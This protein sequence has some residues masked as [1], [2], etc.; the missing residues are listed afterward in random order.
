MNYYNS[1]TLLEQQAEI[2]KLKAERDALAAQVEVLQQHRRELLDLIYNN[3]IGQVAMSYP[4]DGE[5]MAKHAFSITGIDATSTAKELTPAACLAE[6]RAEAGR[7]GFI[8]G[9]NVC[10]NYEGQMDLSELSDQYAERI[11][12]G[13]DV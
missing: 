4:I 11:R 9:F 2:E 10:H 7:A 6:M 1:E 3:A 8:A 5:A 12:Q 13:G